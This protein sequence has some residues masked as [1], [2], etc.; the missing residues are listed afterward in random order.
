MKE[1]DLNDYE[2]MLR[3]IAWHFHKKAPSVEWSDLFQEAYIGFWWA[4]QQW[5]PKKGSFS[6]LLWN[7]ASSQISTF[8]KT[9]YIRHISEDLE[10]VSDRFTVKHDLNESLD[11]ESKE[12]MAELIK[13]PFDF[14][15]TSPK[16]SEKKIIKKMTEKGWD[17]LTIT[18]SIKKITEALKE[19]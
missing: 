8:I 1:P 6:T 19:L 4:V 12:L 2:N 13:T 3:K 10:S 5:D 16:E 17:Y 14:I 7:C 15:S 9:N 11:Q 18:T